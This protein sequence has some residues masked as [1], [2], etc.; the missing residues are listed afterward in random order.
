M[1]SNTTKIKGSLFGS[2][3]ARLDEEFST[4]AERNTAVSSIDVRITS[5][6]T[7]LT[8]EH[9]TISDADS[10]NTRL[11][12]EESTH[13]ADTTSLTTRIAAEESTRVQGTA[14]INLRITAEEGNTTSLNFRISVEE[15][16]SAANLSTNISSVNTRVSV[17][18]ATRT[19]NVSSLAT[20]IST[21]TNSIDA[22]ISV[23]ESTRIANIASI[24]VVLAG[25]DTTTSSINARISVEESTHATDVL[26]LNTKTTG[27]ITSVNNRITTDITSVNVR[28][29]GD[30]TSIN[31][32]ITNDTTSLSVRIGA[33]EIKQT[34][35]VTSLENELSQKPYYNDVD[36]LEGELS[37]N[38]AVRV[39]RGTNANMYYYFGSSGT[40]PG[41]IAT[42]YKALI[43]HDGT[44]LDILNVENGY[45]SFSNKNEEV[46]RIHST[47]HVGIG[48]TAPDEKLHVYGNIKQTVASG[49]IN[50]TITNSG[51]I[52]TTHT[53]SAG[54]AKI[55]LLATNTTKEAVF[56]AY[57]STAGSNTGRLYLGS[58]ASNGGGIAYNYLTADHLIFYRRN[59][60]VDTEFMRVNKG[61]STVEFP[62]HD[63][64]IGSGLEVG[65]SLEVGN[66]VEISSNLYVYG[67]DLELFNEARRGGLGNSSHRRALAHIGGDYLCLNYDFDYT[68]GVLVDSTLLVDT[69]TPKAKLTVEGVGTSTSTL[70]SSYA[71]IIGTSPY[72]Q[73]QSTNDR[74]STHLSIYASAVIAGSS[75]HAYSDKRIKKNILDVEGELEQTYVNQFDQLKLVEYN[76][77]DEYLRGSSRVPG[78]IAQQVAEVN[79]ELVEK[80]RFDVIPNHM[81]MVPLLTAADG[82][83]SLDLTTVDTSNIDMSSTLR[84]IDVS[85]IQHDVKITSISGS[86]YGINNDSRTIPADPENHVILYGEYVDDFHSI[87]QNKLAT[88]H[89]I[90]TKQLDK[91][92]TN[93]DNRLI[94]VNDRL[95]T[96]NNTQI[97]QQYLIDHLY[98]TMGITKPA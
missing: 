34:S 63:V 25:E 82:T 77:I 49:D 83:Y 7:R 46:M 90:K 43:S 16:T 37:T 30:V 1:F 3:T 74:N 36:G 10:I 19:A 45:F 53:S 89:M 75:L 50:N 33:E 15:S 2:A 97:V 22:R 59:A 32:R 8:N 93:V 60:T 13:T 42:Q 70:Y 58:N 81:A 72:Y 24:D 61:G 80:K 76:Y 66:I 40:A 20:S 88:I 41:P 96:T 57:G 86:I 64:V 56:A 51:N 18:E 9:A 29:T 91:K 95:T 68:G 17:E 11:S 85:N 21:N 26:S 62:G 65:S 28:V 73:S 35:D 87:N 52:A 6:N 5:I 55:S 23:E 84:I 67:S 31:N 94:D 92:L 14:S 79:P 47:N 4:D 98:T 54:D 44:N 38:N 71:E 69:A 48:T 39:G 27:D 12:V 78:L